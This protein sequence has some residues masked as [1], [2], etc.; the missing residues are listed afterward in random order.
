MTTSDRLLVGMFAIALSLIGRSCVLTH[1]C[2]G[3][4][5][6]G[7]DPVKCKQEFGWP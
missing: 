1:E 5:M 2:M 7:R 3:G 6:F 4:G